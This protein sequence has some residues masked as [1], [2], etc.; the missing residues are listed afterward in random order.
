MK[1]GWMNSF[2]FSVFP[3]PPIISAKCTNFCIL[4]LFPS[5]GTKRNPTPHKNHQPKF[6]FWLNLHH[7]GYIL[8][9][10]M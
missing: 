8:L 4:N 3:S 7:Y 1:P 9:I 2:S 5:F 6:T 10:S